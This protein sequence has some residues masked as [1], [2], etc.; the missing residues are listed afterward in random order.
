MATPDM[1]VATRDA[2]VVERVSAL[3]LMQ[4]SSDVGAVPNQV[5]A[6]LVLDAGRMFDAEVAV[7][8]LGERIERVPRLRQRL[9]RVAVGCGRP[10]WVD[11]PDFDLARHVTVVA[12]P[13]GDDAAVLEIA[14]ARVGLPVADVAA[15]VVGDVRDR[16]RRGP[17]RAGRGV[18]P[19]AG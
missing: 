12:A 2:R 6:V 16:P 5:G 7:T 13:A 4:L 3:D 8:L 18:P 1:V 9:V 17:G 14:E 11:D 15:A 19:C 10:V